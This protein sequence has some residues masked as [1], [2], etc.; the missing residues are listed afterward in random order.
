MVRTIGLTMLASAGP[1]TVILP[2]EYGFSVAERDDGPIVNP[3]YWVYEALPLFATLT[4]EIDWRAVAASGL[5]LLAP[6]SAT[7]AGLPSDWMALAKGQP[8]P[9]EGFP[10]EFGYNSIRIPL[11]LMRANA[12]ATYLKLF[13]AMGDKDGL[14][15]IDVTTGIAQE[16]LSE[17]G[18]RLIQAALDCTLSGTAIPADL[19]TMTASTYYAATLQLLLLD[20]LRRNQSACLSTE[21]PQ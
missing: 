20:H 19:Q 11:Y 7:R 5:D 6:M 2:G 9:A 17:P 16:R 21:V 3:S 1:H 8:E 10:P 18:Y 4:P 14:A 12:D 15:R 13:S